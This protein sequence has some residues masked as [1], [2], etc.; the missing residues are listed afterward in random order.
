MRSVSAHSVAWFCEKLGKPTFHCHP[1]LK[2]IVQKVFVI[3]QCNPTHLPRQSQ[4]VVV[5]VIQ[6]ITTKMETDFMSHLLLQA[7]AQRRVVPVIAQVRRHHHHHHPMIATL[8]L[9]KVIL[10]ATKKALAV[11]K[12]L[13][14]RYNKWR[15]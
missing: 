9:K 6:S 1:G 12:Q 3:H 4:G 7:T 13:P 5:M 14:I 8:L 2:W 10:V 15:L 11:K